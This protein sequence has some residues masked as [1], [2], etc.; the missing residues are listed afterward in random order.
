MQ[1]RHE[2]EHQKHAAAQLHVLLRR[3]LSH[4]RHAGKHALPFRAR[5]SQQQQEP[6][7]QSQIPAQTHIRLGVCARFECMQWSTRER[8]IGL[9]LV[10]VFMRS[11]FY[12]CICVYAAI[13]IITQWKTLLQHSY[14]NNRSASALKQEART[15]I[16]V[17]L[18]ITEI[19]GITSCVT[20]HWS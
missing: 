11:L 6:S 13:E 1:Q 17:L 18:A 8:C 4:R 3:A 5:L 19:L 9:L 15:V 12:A 16:L 7:T 20:L 2:H 10:F 14:H